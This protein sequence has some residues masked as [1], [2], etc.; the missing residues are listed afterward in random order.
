MY[1]LK[2]GKISIAESR[3][4]NSLESLKKDLDSIYIDLKI[5]KGK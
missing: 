4:I 1:S 3:N 2:Y 5:V